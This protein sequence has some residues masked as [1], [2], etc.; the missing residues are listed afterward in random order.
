MGVGAAGSLARMGESSSPELRVLGHLGRH[1]PPPATTRRSVAQPGTLAVT[2]PR[3][4]VSACF[5][6]REVKEV[7]SCTLQPLQ[8]GAVGKLQELA[9][10]K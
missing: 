1:C 4:A 8:S 2:L 5:P 6:V 7:G 3:P 10:L 9:S